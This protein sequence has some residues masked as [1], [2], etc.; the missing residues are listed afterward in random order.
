[1]TGNEIFLKFSALIF[2]IAELYMKIC[3][4]MI[5]FGSCFLTT[6]KKF[7]LLFE[8][9]FSI[10]NSTIAKSIFPCGSYGSKNVFIE[11]FMVWSTFN[12]ETQHSCLVWG[13]IH[14][15]GIVGV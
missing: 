1:M 8:E 12:G 9:S 10:L 2:V 13:A 14:S 15:L 4:H 6:R 3:G 7:K 11:Y 5:S